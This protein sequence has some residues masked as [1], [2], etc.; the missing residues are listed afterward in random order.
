MGIKIRRAE[1]MVSDAWD[2]P[3]A[4][5]LGL[6]HFGVS[7]GHS[8]WARAQGLCFAFGSTA[9]CSYTPVFLKIQRASNKVRGPFE[10]RLGS[11]VLY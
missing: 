4:E 11:R 6:D 5:L 10:H 8:F 3:S 7:T 1:L 9:G 2:V